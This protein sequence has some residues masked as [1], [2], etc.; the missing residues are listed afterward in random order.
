M[1]KKRK[2]WEKPKFSLKNCKICSLSNCFG[3]S[4]VC[5]VSIETSKI[6]NNRNKRFVADSAETSFGSSFGCFE[7]K[8]VSKDPYLWFPFMLCKYW[9]LFGW[10]W[11]KVGYSLAEHARKLVTHWLSMRKYWLFAGWAFAKIISAHH[12][13]YCIRVFPLSPCHPFLCPPSPVLV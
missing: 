1:K 7:S 6:S 10:A 12:V 4:S 5:F 9:L 2:N 3:W 11:A 8:L 13:H